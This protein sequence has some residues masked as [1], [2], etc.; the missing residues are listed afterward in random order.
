MIK[1]NYEWSFKDVNFTKNKG[2]VFSCFACGG[3]STMGYKL[4]GFDVI[5]HNDIDKRMIEVYKA[6]HKPKYSFL[7]SITTFAKRKD[8]PKELYELDILD[9][10][11]PCSSFSMAGN[12]EKDWG[13]NKKFKEGQAEQVLDTLFFDF[14][15][16]AK[17]L[18]PK[19]VI[20]ENVSGL[21]MGEAKEY[22]KK[23]YVM[24]KQAGYQLKINPYLLDSSLMGIP[25]R[26]KRVFFIA[27]RNDIS[28]E[29][30]YNVDMFQVAPKL[31]LNFNE[32]IIPFKEVQENCNNRKKISKGLL[33]H[34]HKADHTGRAKTEKG[35]TFGFFY[36]AVKDL[37]LAT[38]TSG[39]TYS[40]CNVPELLTDT[41]LCKCGSF[42][43]DYNFC[44]NNTQYLIA[45]SVPPVM[46][47]KIALQVY[48][49]W[50]L[51][52]N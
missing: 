18:Q 24:F 39:C 9:G 15:D 36:K 41:E 27:L 23:I 20:A 47:A 38:I 46:I 30:M 35:N 5:G 52:I 7:E 48:Y 34:W 49:Q 32:K 50:L 40:I 21:I 51:K 12:R 29:F 25:Q 31:Q 19:V 3:G 37:P 14:I 17:E 8:L 45:M 26:R 6:N 42:P 2:K 10:S 28:S 4:A 43:L 1:L 16:L 33:K 13:K 22:V 11:P 44:N